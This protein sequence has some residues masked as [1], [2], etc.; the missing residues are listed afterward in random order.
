MDVV[1]AAGTLAIYNDRLHVPIHIESHT[2]IARAMVEDIGELQSQ[3]E[4]GQPIKWGDRAIEFGRLVNYDDLR[5]L[6]KE[7]VDRA[8]SERLIG[9]GPTYNMNGVKTHI[10]HEDGAVSLPLSLLEFVF[11]DEMFRNTDQRFNALHHGRAG[12]IPHID[13]IKRDKE[14]TIP[15]FMVGGTVFSPGPYFVKIREYLDDAGEIRQ[16]PS[17]ALFDGNRLM[18]T[19]YRYDD[20]SRNRQVEIVNSGSQQTFGDTWVTVDVF[21]SARPSEE[22]IRPVVNWRGMTREQREETHINGL[23]PLD[24]IKA[25]DPTSRDSLLE[26]VSGPETGA[27]VISSH[28]ISK[29]QRGRTPQFMAQNITHA[30]ESFGRYRD[31]PEDLAQL[32][33]FVEALRP[34][35]DRSRLVVADELELRHVPNIV[36]KG[37]VRAIL[38]NRFLGSGVLKVAMSK[39]EHTAVLDLVRQGISIAW[40]N[41]GDLREMHRSGLFVT[42]EGAERIGELDLVV[43]MYGTHH[44]DERAEKYRPDIVD[45][46][47]KLTKLMPAEKLGVAHG[48]MLGMMRLA[49]EVGRQ[50]DIMSLGIGLDL[51][52]RGQKEVNLLPDGVLVM[53]EDERLYRQEM[54]DKLNIISIYSDG[55]YGTL[56]EFAIKICSQKLSSCLPAPTILISKSHLFDS[57]RQQIEEVANQNLGVAWVVNTV[58]L[59]RDHAEAFEVIKDFWEDPQAYWKKAGLSKKE[60]Q[61]AYANHTQ[62]LE[63]MGMRLA[64]NLRRAAETYED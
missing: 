41:D 15:T 20:Y 33:V 14:E 51:S 16:L 36:N 43:A 57:A 7:E 58:E 39:G 19:N 13:S 25:S 56:E 26:A 34:A 55:G 5:K 50:L 54:L 46:F 12:L 8:I 4:P 32:E 22:T 49:D 44:D 38:M 60:I 6:D 30:A 24:V 10:V 64:E 27:L 31:I 40:E 52:Y 17:A 63:L 35:A 1:K 48:N 28:G 29:V 47:T 23:S 3:T 62:T 11:N 9:F 59:V 61:T 53:A 42:P 45:L 21:R 2:P 18:G 37:D